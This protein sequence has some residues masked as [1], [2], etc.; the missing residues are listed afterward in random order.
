MDEKKKNLVS[1]PAPLMLRAKD[2]ALI[3]GI[4]PSTWYEYRSAGL[5]PPSIKL[6]KARLW[7]M[8]HLQRWVELDC[9]S[10]DKF[11]ALE[12]LSNKT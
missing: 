8:D 2:A 9:P 12:K 10:I 11:I 5:L 7:R 4:S 3:C 1:S 6:G